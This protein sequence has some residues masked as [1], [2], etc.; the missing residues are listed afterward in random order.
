[1]EKTTRKQNWKDLGLQNSLKQIL[2]KK[3]FI[4]HLR[5]IIEYKIVK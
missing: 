5:G 1:L 3:L 4:I 2:S